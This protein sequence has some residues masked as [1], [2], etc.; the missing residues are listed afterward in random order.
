MAS[1]ASLDCTH[2]PIKRNTK[3]IGEI[4]VDM[5]ED[6]WYSGDWD[7]GLQHGICMEVL[8]DETLRHQGK[9]NKGNPDTKQYIHDEYCTVF[10]LLVIHVA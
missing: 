8:P 3:G 6:Q 5:D 1:G 7:V 2:F 10:V 9:W 4:I